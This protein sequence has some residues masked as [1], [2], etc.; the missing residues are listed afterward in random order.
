MRRAPD[1]HRELQT[2]QTL[3][4][5]SLPTPKLQVATNT[6]NEGDSSQWHLNRNLSGGCLPNVTLYLAPKYLQIRVDRSLSD[7]LTWLLS[8]NMG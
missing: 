5:E 1:D 2:K 6:Q 8:I 4:R 3:P 7:E